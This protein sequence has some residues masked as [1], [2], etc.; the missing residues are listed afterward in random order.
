[1]K[2][3]IGVYDREVSHNLAIIL[4]SKKIIPIEAESMEEIPSLLD[5]HPDAMLIC[6]ETS[7][8]FYQNLRK[9]DLNVFLLFHPNLNATEL[10]KLRQFGIKLLIP[11]TE[12]ATTII[13]SITNQLS[14]LAN[15]LKKDDKTLITPSQHSNTHVA[16]RVLD[17]KSR[18]YGT[19]LGVNSSK[20]SVSIEEKFSSEITTDSNI[21]M[22]LQGL[23]IKVMADLVYTNNNNYVFRY[24]KMPKEDAMRLAYFINYCQKNTTTEKMVMNI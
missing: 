10:L 4:S 9:K 15:Q 14:M 6:E 17:T 23:N 5:I 3:I 21:V 2:I 12:N 16:I 1:M 24:R 11:Y 8:A 22:H 18:V 19:L 13:E 20:V 7:L